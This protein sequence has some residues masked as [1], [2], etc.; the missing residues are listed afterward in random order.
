M[1]TLRS[2]TIE[3][4]GTHDCLA[5]VFTFLGEGQLAA[6]ALEETVRQ[7][8]RRREGMN[9]EGQAE[10]KGLRKEK[11]G[12]EDGERDTKRVCG[13]PVERPACREAWER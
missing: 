1:T 11:R 2:S 8:G 10:L 12:L 9:M 6:A 7:K 3:N 4:G 13:H 5:R